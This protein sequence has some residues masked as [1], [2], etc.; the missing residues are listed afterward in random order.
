MVRRVKT[1]SRDVTKGAHH[2]AFIGGAQCVT[3]VLN[4]PQI[5]LFAEGRHK[6]QVKRVAQAVRQHDGFGFGAD[7]G[8]NLGRIDVVG[9]QVNVHKYRHCTKLQDRVD[10]GWEACGHTNH[11]IARL[12]GAAAQAWTGER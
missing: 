3:A 6:F 1:E 12:N 7:G 8:F 11:F 9:S 5:V 4:H 2:L 10:C